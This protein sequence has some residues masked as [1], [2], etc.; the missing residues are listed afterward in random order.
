MRIA[1]VTLVFAATF[2]G[3]AHARLGETADQL[4]Q[5]YGQPL[6]E[7]DQKGEGDKIAMADVVF[8]KGGFQVNVTVVDG[9]S[10]EETFKKLNGQALS[11][12][13]VRILLGANAQGREW[14]A[15][16]DLHGQKVWTRD[17]SAT[18]RVNPD[19]SLTIKSRELTVK[20]AIAKKDER[21]PTL[22]GF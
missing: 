4:V 8:E 12:Q 17:D 1:L 13:E 22:D 11:I 6:S 18:A 20:E 19:G 7:N 14:E 21:A 10:V 15:P 5:R 16:Q 9:L 2:A 3:T